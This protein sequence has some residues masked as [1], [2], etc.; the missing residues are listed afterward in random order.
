MLFLSM[1][2]MRE[3][4]RSRNLSREWADSSRRPIEMEKGGG[5]TPIGTLKPGMPVQLDGFVFRTIALI[6]SPPS[7]VS[8]SWSTSG[9]KHDIAGNANKSTRS[10]I[11]RYSSTN[12]GSLTCRHSSNVS[13]LIDPR[14]VSKTNVS[15]SSLASGLSILAVSSS[16]LN[17]I[18]LS[19]RYFLNK[20]RDW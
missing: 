17:G 15:K 4:H 5:S 1:L 9:G 14:P 16:R 18:W 3:P 7:D 13:R 20:L 2:W 10:N 6:V 19:T 8:S 11:R 12:C